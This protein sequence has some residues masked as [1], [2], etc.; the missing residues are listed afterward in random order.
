M[1][2]VQQLSSY[3]PSDFRFSGDRSAAGTNPRSQTQTAQKPRIAPTVIACMRSPIT[4][5]VSVT[6]ITKMSGI[7]TAPTTTYASPLRLV[8]DRCFLHHQATGPV[9]TKNPTAAPTISGTD[10]VPPSQSRTADWIPITP[11]P[12]KRIESRVRL[13]HELAI[14]NGL[15]ANRKFVRKRSTAERKSNSETASLE[16]PLHPSREAIVWSNPLIR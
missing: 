3:S 5:I 6:A 1:G 15:K 9:K 10:I 8:L 2:I 7:H 12:P 16:I 11:S 14:P 4:P 13:D